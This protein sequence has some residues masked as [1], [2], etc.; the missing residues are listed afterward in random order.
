MAPFR[1]VIVGGGI[2][3]FTAA[4]ALRGPNRHITILE[5]STLNKEIGALISLQPNA[6]RIVESK[7]NLSEELLEARQMVDEGFRIYNT[8]GH[9]VN[10]IPLLTKEKYGA[11]RLLFHRRDLH[12]TLKRAAV[13]P[14][15]AGDPAIVRVSSRVVDCDA[16]K[17]TVTLDSGEIVE[18]DF[19]IGADGIHSVLRRHVLEEAI[20]PMPTGYSAYRLMIPT[21]ILEKEEPDFCA[22]INPQEPFTSMIVAHDCRLIMG[23]GRQGEVYG[24]VALVPDDQMTEDPHAKQSWVA[25]GDLKKMMETFAEFP[26]WVKNIFKHS[27]DLGLWQLRDL[28]PLQTWHRGR[29]LIIGDAAHAMLPTQGQG[30]SQA[31]EDSEALGAFFE[32]IVEPPSLEILTKALEDIFQARYARACLIQAY[33]RQA[34][35]PATAQGN[36][37]VTMK[38]DE[39]MDFNCGYRGAKEW[40]QLRE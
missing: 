3:G 12:E 1:I 20:S 23:P 32:E 26:S 11:E 37:G 31:I 16:L 17:G 10:T 27:A 6:S 18:G 4:I 19:I 39:F 13:S 9:L 2:A 25:E 7:W 15:R 5:Q 29:V 40:K 36:I 28:D 14:T 8:E 21:E 34:A 35:K 33:S 30:A 22:K 24:I 38:P